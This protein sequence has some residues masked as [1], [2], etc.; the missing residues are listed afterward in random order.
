MFSLRSGGIGGLGGSGNG[1][2]TS[3]SMSK[4]SFKAEGSGHSGSSVARSGGKGEDIYFTPHYPG[5]DDDAI[6][7]DIEHIN[8]I[9]E[10]EDDVAFAGSR[11]IV[12]K[13]KAVAKSGL[14]PV[15]LQ[16]EE[17]KERATVVNTAP[18]VN[19]TS[20]EKQQIE[21]KEEGLFVLDEPRSSNY[22]KVTE[23]VNVE[24]GND[25]LVEPRIKQESSIEIELNLN[26][27]QTHIP[28]FTETRP[29]HSPENNYKINNT[30]TAHPSGA[31]SDKTT[32]STANVG[33][34]F[35]KSSERVSKKL[36]REP[37][38]QTEEDRAEYERYLED[39]AILS[40]ELGCLQD[41]NS[42]KLIDAEGDEN[43]DNTET[44]QEEQ[45]KREG[46][47][48]LFQFPPVL[49]ALY[50][51]ESAKNIGSAIKIKQ[52]NTENN[53]LDRALIEDKDLASSNQKGKEKVRE[54]DVSANSPVIKLEIEDAVLKNPRED[55]PKGDETINEEGLIGK[56]IVRESGRVELSWGGT[57][58]LLGRGVDAGFLTTGVIVD[59]V[60]R[61][62]RGG[63]VP[64][65]RAL[66]MGQIM[67]KFVVTPDW[68]N[69]A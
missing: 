66:G 9:S 48:Y 14:R 35:H 59:S 40:N 30:L 52:E 55:I 65:G 11:K 29:R 7:I 31:P 32:A 63:G 46:R 37:V 60:E 10:D 25:I 4:V 51:P 44:V 22:N 8:L 19:V 24:S 39:V 50:N 49:P 33:S 26:Q 53:D 34:N 47:L 15:R 54:A 42:S 67:G 16:R 64:E 62:P 61:G 43:M 23:T 69:M 6:R 28:E 3:S 13:G 57:G 18:T 20:P 41:S 45:D 5:E 12:D 56:L 68:K 36:A 2:G 58:L 21:D 1:S 27:P 17:H 38:F